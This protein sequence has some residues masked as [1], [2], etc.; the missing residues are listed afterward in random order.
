[1]S[2]K[3]VLALEAIF[4]FLNNLLLVLLCVS[5]LKHFFKPILR[6]SIDDTTVSR[7][8]HIKKYPNDDNDDDVDDDD[9]TDLNQ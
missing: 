8:S 7:F 6:S 3:N 1:M 4:F 5:P 2:R 9:A